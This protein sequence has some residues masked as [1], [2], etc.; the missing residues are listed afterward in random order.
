[1][2]DLVIA[3]SLEGNGLGFWSWEPEKDLY[4]LSPQWAATTGLFGDGTA[5]PIAR[6]KA[7]IYPDDRARWTAAVEAARR[8]VQ[9]GTPNAKG[10]A[11]GSSKGAELSRYLLE[12]R[13]RTHDSK[14]SAGWRWVQERGANRDG[15]LGGVHLDLTPLKQAEVDV[16]D[17]AELFGAVFAT[18]RAGIVT[19]NPGDLRIFSFNDAACTMLGYERRDFGRLTLTDLTAGRVSAAAMREVAQNGGGDV[20]LSLRRDAGR[21]AITVE[22]RFRMVHTDGRPRLA[23]I[24]TQTDVQQRK[25]LESCEE[26]HGLLFDNPVF[27][28]AELDLEGQLQRVNGFLASLFGREPKSLSDLKL[29]QQVRPRDADQD[30]VNIGQ[31]LA[32][33]IPTYR[34]RRQLLGE[35]GKK[36][37]T[38][39]TLSLVRGEAQKPAGF[40]AVVEDL[41]PR[42][43]LNLRVVE[44]RALSSQLLG[45]MSQPALICRPLRGTDTHSDFEIQALNPPAQRLLG[46]AEPSVIGRRLFQTLPNFR[47]GDLPEAMAKADHRHIEQVEAIL[48]EPPSS[49]GAGSGDAGSNGQSAGPRPCKVTVTATQ[50]RQLLL[51]LDAGAQGASAMHAPLE[52]A[53]QM[54][55][56]ALTGLPGLGLFQDR[57]LQAAAAADANGSSVAVCCLDINDFKGVN[58]IH[59][60]ET[61]D[62]VL[63][64]VATRLREQVSAT[65]TV[66]CWGGDNFG[67]LLTGIDSVERCTERLQAALD[68][69][70]AP[71][72]IGPRTVE[73]TASMGVALY[74]GDRE[75]A[76]DLV[77]YATQALRQCQERAACGFQFINDKA[78]GISSAYRDRLDRVEQS[79]ALDQLT[80]HVQPIVELASGRPVAAEVLLRWTHPEQGVLGAD[81]ILPGKT[82]VHL[83]RRI[84]LWVLDHA[85]PQLEQWVELGLELRLHVNISAQTLI[86][87]GFMQ[88]LG[89]LLD[90]YPLVPPDRLVIEVQ[91]S[92]AETDI[93]AVAETIRAG[94]DLGVSFAL[95][96][97]GTGATSMTYFR[98][99]SAQL[100]KID[101]S[102]VCDMLDDREARSIVTALAGVAQGFGRRALAVGVESAAHAKALSE[103][104]CTLGQGFGI[105]EPMPMSELP[106][107]LDEWRPEAWGPEAAQDW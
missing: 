30:R 31:L 54:A 106:E 103:L 61:G 51:L 107:W 87:G 3:P 14:G 11:T 69:V 25:A 44:A 10:D 71:C 19:V 99:L 98:E 37:A 63:K 53:G 20:E 4:Q 8:S 57:I 22:A 15:V 13:I 45:A 1:M 41:R 105:A 5:V 46:L 70:A 6:W 34:S 47:V 92:A 56:D 49:A 100:L 75:Q 40:V 59:G 17:S 88:V 82:G 79:L 16:K 24:W 29:T 39:W 67:L 2:H 28:V 96:D 27:G 81:S 23:G 66:A 33:E 32:G 62:T 35:H 42:Q 26:R 95:D 85:L 80:L 38:D 90:A 73:L 12:Y 55:Q 86:H 48:P 36:V 52:A 76:V 91:E 93:D 83:M 43:L 84:D 101:Q 21:S 72:R 74:P 64:Q 18:A 102:F 9:Q 97:F 7:L 50:T 77:R 60:R 65:D 78:E 89:M 104:G 94:Q 58:E 68:A